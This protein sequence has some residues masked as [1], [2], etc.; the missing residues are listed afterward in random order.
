MRLVT[1][2]GPI[3]DGLLQCICDLYGRYV[4]PRYQQLQFVRTVF[5]GNPIGYSYHAFLYEGQEAVGCYS[6]IP[7]EVISR[8]RLILAGKGEALFLRSEYRKGSAGETQLF[9]PG[10]TLIT[11]AHTLAR[12]D[13]IDL[14]FC[15]APLRLRSIFKATGFSRLNARLDHRYFLLR[16]QAIRQLAPHLWRRTAASVISLAQQCP[17]RLVGWLAASSLLPR[18]RVGPNY[19]AHR[20]RTIAARHLVE[21]DRWSIAVTERSL[22]WWMTMSHLRAITVDDNDEECVLIVGGAPKSNLE[23]FD[24]HLRDN[25]TM[26]ALRILSYIVRIADQQGVATISF[27]KRL[28]GNRSLSRAATLLGFLSWPVERVMFVRSTDPFHSVRDN[29]YFDSLFSL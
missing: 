29:I 20:L 27:A 22:S 7:M 21:P 9:A 17:H 24:W 15:L 1:V 28:S 16:P 3:N 5:N 10:L 26:R 11:H 6:I 19:D 25:H 12:K 23:I 4:N 14:L 2:K 18:L 8:D 13:G